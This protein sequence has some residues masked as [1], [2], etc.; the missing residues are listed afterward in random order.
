MNNNVIKF[1]GW[2]KSFVF[3]NEYTLAVDGVMVSEVN[4]ER[5]IVNGVEYRFEDLEDVELRYDRINFDCTFASKKVVIN[6]IKPAFF[7]WGF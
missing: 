7:A 3:N 5:I 2:L 6:L 1:I 4:P